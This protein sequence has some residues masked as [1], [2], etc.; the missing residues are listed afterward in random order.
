MEFY[1]LIDIREKYNYYRFF[2]FGSRKTKP[3]SIVYATLRLFRVGA[4]VVVPHYYFGEVCAA[5][6]RMRDVL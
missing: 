2:L 1:F 3:R 4:W 6:V 5:V